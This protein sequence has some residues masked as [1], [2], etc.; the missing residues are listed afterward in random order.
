MFFD[1]ELLFV[2]WPRDFTKEFIIFTLINIGL[3]ELKFF[4]IFGVEEVQRYAKIIYLSDISCQTVFVAN[5]SFWFT[6]SR[7]N[8]KAKILQI[9]FQIILR[10]LSTQKLTNA[11]QNDKDKFLQI[12]VF[13]SDTPLC[14]NTLNK[15]LLFLATKRVRLKVS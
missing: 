10:S 2:K 1:L 7:Q 15:K 12:A 4:E 14:K 11:M 13:L 9:L 5:I 8:N 6:V 3:Q